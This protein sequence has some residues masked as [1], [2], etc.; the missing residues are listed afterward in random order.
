MRD[1]K[2]HGNGYWAGRY[3]I[4]LRPH[5]MTSIQ[6]RSTIRDS[7]VFTSPG[8]QQR[9]KWYLRKEVVGF[10]PTTVLKRIPQMR[11]MWLRRMEMDQQLLGNRY[12]DFLLLIY[13]RYTVCS[14]Y[15]SPVKCTIE[16]LVS[17]QCGGGLRFN[18]LRFDIHR[19]TQGGLFIGT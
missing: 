16:P 15:D 2:A 1:I 9:M 14:P 3:S 11:C 10:V 4:A 19:P 8:D 18:W 12:L 17:G 6:G 7:G 5:S 13:Y